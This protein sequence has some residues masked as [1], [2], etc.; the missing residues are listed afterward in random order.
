LPSYEN[1]VQ[2]D[3]Q[4]GQETGKFSPTKVIQSYLV[5]LLAKVAD[6]YDANPDEGFSTAGTAQ[7]LGGAEDLDPISKLN[8][9]SG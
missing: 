1:D 2:N 7:I 8:C 9:R 4:E 5:K 3:P 6:F